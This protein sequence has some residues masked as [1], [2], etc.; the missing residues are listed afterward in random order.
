VRGD[1]HIFL[2]L[3]KAS[4]RCVS[5]ARTAAI[6]REDRLTK[7]LISGIF[8]D[9]YFFDLAIQYHKTIGWH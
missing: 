2:P 4:G 6:I 9:G 7:S 1:R 8:N 3:N 5:I